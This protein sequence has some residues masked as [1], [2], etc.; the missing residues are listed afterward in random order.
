MKK[1]YTC[2]V[3]PNGCEIEAEIE[4]GKVLSVTGATCKNGVEYVNNELTHPMRTITSSVL[5]RNGQLPL[6]SVKLD[7]PIPKDKIFA[8]MAEIK[9]ISIVAPVTAE[10]IIIPDILGLGSNVVATKSVGEI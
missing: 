7:A 4:G 8:V 2:I 9:K 1:I 5:V 6:V 3:C 10:Q